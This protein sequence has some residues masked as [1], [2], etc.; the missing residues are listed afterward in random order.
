MLGALE[1]NLAFDPYRGN[2]TKND[3]INRIAF[4]RAIDACHVTPDHSIVMYSLMYGESLMPGRGP[5]ISRLVRDTGLD[6]ARIKE[7]LEDIEDIIREM[8]VL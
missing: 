7:I 5:A 8:E 4:K 1:D 2:H 3:V 6:A